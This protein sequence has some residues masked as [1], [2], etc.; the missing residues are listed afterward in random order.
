MS[1]PVAKV[2]EPAASAA[3]APPDDPPG[4]MFRFHGLRVIPQRFDQV[5]AAQE[6]SGVALRACTMPPA[7]STR[8]LIGEVAGC[9]MSLDRSEPAD[10]GS[11][12][13]WPE[14]FTATQIPS[15]G[16]GLSA[17]L[18]IYRFSASRAASRA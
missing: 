18:P 15:R 13:I 4:V 11:P 14:S 3:A 7:R 10:V 2:A 8:W 6:Y 16:Y 17:V 5:T 1:D 9:A 12:A